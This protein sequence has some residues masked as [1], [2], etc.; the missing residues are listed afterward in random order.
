MALAQAPTF[1]DVLKK[2]PLHR[3]IIRAVDA[4]PQGIAKRLLT[5]TMPVTALVPTD[6]VRLRL[7]HG[8]F[9]ALKGLCC[10]CGTT[11]CMCILLSDGSSHGVLC[12]PHATPLSSRHWV[13]LSCITTKLQAFVS[14]GIKYKMG[15]RPED[16]QRIFKNTCLINAIL[17]QHIIPG[18]YN[19]TQLHSVYEKQSLLITKKYDNATKKAVA[20]SWPLR[21]RT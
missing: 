18:V 20:V 12:V 13:R 6:S 8:Q 4:D 21:F 15:T 11:M 5:Q 14:A 10:V 17:R 2:D 19:T 1:Y 3:L 7:L 9:M 16:L